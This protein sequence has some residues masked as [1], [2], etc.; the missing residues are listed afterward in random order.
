MNITEIA[1]KIKIVTNAILNHNNNVSELISGLRDKAVLIKFS[2]N[3]EAGCNTKV[4]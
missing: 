3:F 1:L 4:T 2:S